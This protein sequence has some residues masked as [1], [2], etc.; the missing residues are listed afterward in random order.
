MH[1]IGTFTRTQTHATKFESVTVLHH[2]LYRCDGAGLRPKLLN[3]K[4]L[5]QDRDVS[6]A[7]EFT[8]EMEKSNYVDTRYVQ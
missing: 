2:T 7:Q 4:L 1:L 8:D 5:K 6:T 3:K